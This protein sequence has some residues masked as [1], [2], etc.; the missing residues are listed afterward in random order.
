VGAIPELWPMPVDLDVTAEAIDLFLTGET[1]RLK[2][3][4]DWEKLVIHTR[5]GEKELI[6]D[7]VAAIAGPQFDGHESRVY[8]NDGQVLTGRLEAGEA[9]FT[10][11]SIAFTSASSK[12]C[13]SF[14]CTFC[15]TSATRWPSLMRASASPRCGSPRRSPTW[16]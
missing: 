16:G 11:A 9:R 5:F 1:T 7:Q 8:L 4:V 12:R 3:A 6:R 14:T 13:R 15:W 2:G 10:L